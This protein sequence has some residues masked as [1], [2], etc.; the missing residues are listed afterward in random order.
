MITERQLAAS[1]SS[2]WQTLM[3]GSE[4]FI[5]RVNLTAKRIFPFYRSVAGSRDRGLVNEA[6]FRLYCIDPTCVDFALLDFDEAYV[7]ASNYIARFREYSESPEFRGLTRGQR[8]ESEILAARLRDTIKKQFPEGSITTQPEFA[9][10]GL[11]SR[12]EGDVLVDQTLLEVKAG[13]RNFRLIDFRQILVYLSLNYADGGSYDIAAMGFVNP[14]SGKVFVGD[15]EDVCFQVSGL[16]AV[17]VFEEIA[18]FVCE[19]GLFATS[20]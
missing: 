2:F 16:S 8:E 9:G 18:D 13:E 14:R 12:C 4:R 15:L 1:Y 6:A 20:S 19:E 5:R 11:V 10:C 17:E 7:A 3:P